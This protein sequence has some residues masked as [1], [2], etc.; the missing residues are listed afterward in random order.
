MS[1]SYCVSD[2]HDT[3]VEGKWGEEGEM[4][5]YRTVLLIPADK[6]DNALGKIKAALA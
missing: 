3:V 6:M 4:E 1:F 5:S 2:E